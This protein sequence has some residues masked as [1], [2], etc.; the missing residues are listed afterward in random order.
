[1]KRVRA[2]I[3]C[4]A[5]AG[6]A[7][8]GGHEATSSTEA[9]C[10]ALEQQLADLSLRLEAL[11]RQLAERHAV[12]TATAPPEAQ[13]A[14][15]PAGREEALALY[16]RVDTLIA[17][18]EL[19]QA[20]KELSVWETEHAGRPEAAWTRALDREV[21]VVGKA[22]PDDWSIEKWYQGESEVVLDGRQAT[23]VV[24]WEAWCPHC[25]NEVPKLQA[26]WE[27]Y[28]D[29]GLQV[30]GVTRL[31]QSVTEDSVLAFL[32]ESGV[33]YPM[34]KETG[35]LATYFDVKGIP[36][37]AMVKDGKVVWRGHPTRLDDALLDTW[38]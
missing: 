4:A 31:T 11:E 23:L 38:F 12:P 10:T 18:G 21:A 26:V 28:R 17:Q 8:A 9:R 5:V 20:T 16:K 19:E 14:P 37:A 25:K 13:S 27:K 24:F 7:S 32:A 33:R 6:F 15:S 34:A 2:S 29:R 1:M 35:D 30:I 36:A 3:L 22:A